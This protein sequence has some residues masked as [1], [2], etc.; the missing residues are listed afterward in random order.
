MIK[1]KGDEYW[2]YTKP[3]KFCDFFTFKYIDQN[4]VI[5]KST[6]G[7]N[8]SEENSFD[9]NE[10]K[11]EIFKNSLGKYKISFIDKI[12]FTEVPSVLTFNL[13]INKIFG[14]KREKGILWI[15]EINKES[16]GYSYDGNFDKYFSFPVSS[17]LSDEYEIILYKEEK[18]KR[19][20]F[21]KGLLS[22]SKFK[23]GNNYQ[24]SIELTKLSINY[25]AHISLPNKIP[26][27]EEKYNP[28]IMHICAI[29]AYN[30]P[31]KLDPY[32]LC[33]LERD[34][35]GVTTQNLEKTSN[36]Q[37]YEFIDL[38]ITDEKEDLIV[39]IWNKTGKKD[40]LIC[41][42]KIN[43][44]KY[45][46]GNIYYEWLKMDKVSLNIAIQIKREGE[47]KMSMDDI[48]IYQDSTIPDTI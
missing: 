21:S 45:L 39:E 11:E 43:I 12:K 10:C 16:T 28:L 33:R 35:T 24:D 17:L 20:E 37:W 34:K 23:I 1:L 8:L 5:I 6:D 41:G 4:S 2:R 29:E 46:D 3:G 47:S 9:I 44:Q 25:K 40:K 42:T 27:I 31:S 30:I 18:G 15:A 19:K 13:N 22:I 36:P 26:F 14:V 48:Y 32:V 38:I 7:I